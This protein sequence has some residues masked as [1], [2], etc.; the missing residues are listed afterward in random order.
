MS[1]QRK[2]RS[3]IVIYMGLCYETYNSNRIFT[4]VSALQQVLVRPSLQ[5]DEPVT[6]NCYDF[7]EK[8]DTKSCNFMVGLKR[9]VVRFI[10]YMLV[11]LI[12][13]RLNP[14]L[15]STDKRLWEAR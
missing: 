11:V 5:S 6:E 7:L 13:V 9:G 8:Y 4:C 10:A 15:I 2:D 12:V 14:F 3:G 1:R